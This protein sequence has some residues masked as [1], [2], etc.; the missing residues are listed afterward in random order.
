M[1]NNVY[2]R[3]R[4]RW[5]IIAGVLCFLGGYT[6]LYLVSL[7]HESYVY[8]HEI[9]Y[10]RA[11][12]WKY[13]ATHGAQIDVSYYGVRDPS[14]II[15]I[16]YERVPVVDEAPADESRFTTAAPVFSQGVSRTLSA[17]AMLGGITGTTAVLTSRLEQYTL[18]ADLTAGAA[19]TAGYYP[20]A[21]VVGY[22]L[23]L[24]PG[25]ISI[26]PDLVETALLAGIL[27]PL[28]LGTFGGALGHRLRPHRRVQRA[29]AKEEGTQREGGGRPQPSAPQRE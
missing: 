27:V 8:Q 15:N 3:S 5:G 11:M 29:I 10:G 4:L 18:K 9:G 7:L 20:M 6:L 26:G 28:S 17:V 22:L 12:G 25:A 14:K 16:G 13:L 23:Q 24:T 1:L 21:L 19:V 2:S